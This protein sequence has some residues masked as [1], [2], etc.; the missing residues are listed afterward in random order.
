[1]QMLGKGTE[2]EDEKDCNS[3]RVTMMARLWRLSGQILEVL[4][5]SIHRMSDFILK[6][7]AQRRILNRQCNNMSERPKNSFF[8]QFGEIR[9]VKT[10]KVKS[11]LE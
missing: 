11:L 3:K 10:G 2:S 4:R 7:G 8:W 1:M 9:A 5:C 6:A